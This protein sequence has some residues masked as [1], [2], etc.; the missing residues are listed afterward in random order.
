M[1]NPRQ[2]SLHAH[3][4]CSTGALRIFRTMQEIKTFLDAER[5]GRRSRPKTYCDAFGRQYTFWV[6]VLTTSIN[7]A[8]P[9]IRRDCRP[10][11]TVHGPRFE[12]WKYL[13]FM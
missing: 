5:G 3:Y 12:M 6:I 11:C 4:A 7:D 1:P 9:S 13:G 8:Y 10:Y 2:T